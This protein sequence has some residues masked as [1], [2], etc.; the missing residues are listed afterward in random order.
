MVNK[1]KYIIIHCT[2]VSQKDAWDQFDSVNRYH[3]GLGFTR[4]NSGLYVGYHRLITG[5]RN[6]K[7][8]EDDEEGCHTNQS[9]N[10][11]SINFQSLGVCVGFDGDVE[12]PSPEHMKLLKEQVKL[13]QEQHNIPNIFVKFH[14]YFNLYKTCPGGLIKQN[15]LDSILEP[16]EPTYKPESQQK[17]QDALINIQN[18]LNWIEKAII[19]LQKLI[20]N[21]FKKS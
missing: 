3:K 18:Q 11:Q 8:K 10:G 17:K 7:C 5:G 16:S 2:D 1:P 14:R 19:K 12:F 21:L 13:W 15:W 6:Y 20:N 9:E 4:S